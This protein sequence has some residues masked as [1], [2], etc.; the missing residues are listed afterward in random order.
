MYLVFVTKSFFLSF[1]RIFKNDLEKK[2]R[3]KKYNKVQI[4]CFYLK[5]KKKKQ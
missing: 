4:T 3:N 1:Y 5:I 2:N